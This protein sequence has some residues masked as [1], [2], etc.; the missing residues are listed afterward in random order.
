MASSV[1]GSQLQRFY[2]LIANNREINS[3]LPRPS[4]AIHARGVAVQPAVAVHAA[5][6]VTGHAGQ[7]QHAG[8]RGV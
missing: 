6:A 1:Y 3:M 8:R 7:P 2:L 5:E 4:P